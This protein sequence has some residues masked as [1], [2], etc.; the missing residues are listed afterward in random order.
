[1][2]G[3]DPRLFDAPTSVSEGVFTAVMCVPPCALTFSGA[4]A[5]RVCRK[6]GVSD[7]FCQAAEALQR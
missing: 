1:M 7:L 3:A 5:G 4:A 2:N 6:Q